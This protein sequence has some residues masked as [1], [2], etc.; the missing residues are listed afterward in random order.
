[1]FRVFQLFWYGRDYLPPIMFGNF[2][3]AMHSLFWTYPIMLLPLSG[4]SGP[5]LDIRKSEY[6]NK[7]LLSIP[8]RYAHCMILTAYPSYLIFSHWRKDLVFAT[9]I[10]IGQ[11]AI[12]GE[13][14]L[15][16]FPGGLY[17]F[18]FSCCLG[19]FILC[20]FFAFIP[21]SLVPSFAHIWSRS[22][23][24]YDRVREYWN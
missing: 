4:D 8:L 10:V 15:P 24:A 12:I 11:A 19:V 21:N 23:A 22:K 7:K 1:M 16:D 3:I 2:K 13:F 14:G 17:G 18:S 6:R 9:T 5:F 20:H